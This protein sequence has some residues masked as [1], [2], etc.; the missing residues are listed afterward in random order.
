MSEIALE[1]TLESAL[2]PSLERNRR[3]VSVL[4]RAIHYE[5]I[6]PYL[7]LLPSFILFGVFVYY[8][9]LKTIY[10]SFSLT[11]RKGQAVEFVGLENY[12]ELVTSKSFYNSLGV[13]FKF[14]LLII[15]PTM[16]ISL[17]LALLADNKLKYN[18]TYELMFSIPMAIASAPA[19]MIW[20]L[21]FHP[22]NGIANY[23]LHTNI[24]WLADPKTAI[25]VVAFVT[26]WLSLGMN[27]IF[28]F[29]G[30]KSVPKELIESANIDGANYLG[31]VKSVILPLLTPQL[32][33]VLF[34]NLVGAFQAF[35]Q[36]KLL[37]QGGPGDSTNVI[38]HSIY[39]DAFF[40]G[41]FEM[42]SSQS[43]ILFIIIFGI[44]LIQFA[45]EK[46]GVHYK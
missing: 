15:I 29:T 18:R 20:M 6:V 37:T 31:K 35:G 2:N 7:Y 34:M 27:F 11:N 19:A 22:T 1:P 30:L 16:V 41:R 46:K 45:F 39:R 38:V 10:L 42:A 43:I 17:G 36:I 9:F 13:T 26:V 4:R 8:P 14:A 5:K 33:F 40:N 23:L 28:L 3:Q 21:I 44:T 24:R 12:I 32:F 25:Y